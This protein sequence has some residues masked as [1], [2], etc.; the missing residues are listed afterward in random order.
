MDIFLPIVYKITLSSS[1]ISWL[2][3]FFAPLVTPKRVQHNLLVSAK[4]PAFTPINFPNFIAPI[5]ICRQK[6][7]RGPKRITKS[8]NLK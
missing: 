4:D 3:A 7:I 2:L 1:D 6:S 8:N 5:P